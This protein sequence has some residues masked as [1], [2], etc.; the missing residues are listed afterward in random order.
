[1]ER[2]SLVPISLIVLF[3]LRRCNSHSIVDANYN[4]FDGG[5]V[6]SCKR[7]SFLADSICGQ[8]VDYEV[9]SSIARLV[10]IL[11]GLIVSNA[12]DLLS[13]SDG[14]KDAYQKILCIQRFPQ[15]KSNGTVLLGKQNATLFSQ[16]REEC[17][18]E[19]VR[20]VGD[21]EVSV[22]RANTCRPVEDLV[23]SDFSFARCHID[24][25]NPMTLWMVEYLKLVDRTI[26]NEQGI[27]YTSSGCGAMFSSYICDYIGR[28]SEDGVN[29]EYINTYE[30]C[31]T[32]ISW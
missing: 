3:F 32:V 6:D 28:C 25:T 16:L 14:C 10:Q 13:P 23:G 31:T 5:A 1:M 22:Q 7:P 9:P 24:L 2:T 29:V 20:R 17:A 11:E 12:E 8:V 15:C 18:D 19:V 4:P 30:K 27:V 21:Q 26:S